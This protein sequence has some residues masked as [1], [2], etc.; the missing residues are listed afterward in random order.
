MTP[1]VIVIGTGPAGGA[2]A[3]AL[4]Q[5]G[6][7]TLLIDAQKLPRKKP[8]GGALPAAARAWLG[9]LMADTLEA[10]VSVMRMLYRGANEH[11]I[12]DSAAS[13]LLV[14]RARFD[15]AYAK[16]AV[17]TGHVTL[18]D[19]CRIRSINQ[20]GSSVTV[21]TRSGELLNARYVV[22]ASGA[23]SHLVE[24]VDA[25]RAGRFGLALE[26]TVSAEMAG[27]GFERHCTQATFDYDVAPAGYAWIFPKRGELSCG[28][29]GMASV[30]NLR[31]ALSAFLQREIPEL[32]ASVS[33]TG[34]IIPLYVTADRSFGTGR[35][36]IAGDAASLVD[37][38]SGEGIWYALQSGALA[39]RICAWQL[40]AADDALDSFTG[41]R[42][43]GVSDRAAA[44]Y[45]AIL[46]AE[47]TG[48][49]D[50]MAQLALPDYLEAPEYFYK[51]FI[52]PGHRHVDFYPRLLN[53]RRR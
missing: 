10:E 22:I 52:A 38:I 9:K 36:L 51:T 1:D 43:K 33:S 40:G 47:L 24:H 16:Q 19:N 45:E 21:E 48:H 28:I 23:R 50:A 37:P 30:G 5:A 27:A 8:C 15:Y 25:R 46:A 32:T 39:G 26:T 12:E 11:V 49:L 42:G 53:A 7:A 20:S 17:A 18:R 14:N 13:M 3:N 41:S 44:T 34:H 6:V 35:C 31:K 4:G 29:G 2:A